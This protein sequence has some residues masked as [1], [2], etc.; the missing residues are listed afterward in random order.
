MD[1][2]VSIIS[3]LDEFLEYVPSVADGEPPRIAILGNK[4]DITTERKVWNTHVYIP[5]PW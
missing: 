3:W 5:L 1:Q 2:K 4:A